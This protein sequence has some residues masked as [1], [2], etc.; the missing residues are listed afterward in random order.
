MKESSSQNEGHFQLY[1]SLNLN[2]PIKLIKLLY[3]VSDDIFDISTQNLF[4]FC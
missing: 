1:G 2:K 4:I 3:K